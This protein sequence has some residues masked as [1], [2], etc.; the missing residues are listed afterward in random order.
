MEG[1]GLSTILEAVYGKNGVHQMTTGKAVNRAFRSHLLVSV[2]TTSE[3]AES[4]PELSSKAEEIYA[5]LA[6]GDPATE[7]QEAMRTEI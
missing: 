5:A 4:E 7:A 2:L 1:L 6:E 3:L